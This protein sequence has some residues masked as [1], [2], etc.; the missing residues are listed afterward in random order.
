MRQK[1]LGFTLVEALVVAVLMAILAAVTIPIYNGFIK[2]GK[3]DVVKNLSQTAATAANSYLRRNGVSPPAV[4]DL[5]LF[6]P[7]PTLY[8]IVIDGD[9]KTVTVSEVADP[10]ITSSTHFN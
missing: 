1:N 2:S 7:D 8:T 5:N 10:T 4:T 6:L 9:A 3:Q